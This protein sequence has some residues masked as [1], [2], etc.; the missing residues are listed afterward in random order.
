MAKESPPAERIDWRDTQTRNITLLAVLRSVM[1]KPANWKRG[2]AFA[3]RLGVS[4]NSRFR[5]GPLPLVEVKKVASQAVLY[6]DR[7][8]ASGELQRKF[9]R[10]QRQRG[11]LGGVA[12][13]K[14][15]A[16]VSNAALLDK[17]L[18]GLA[19]PRANRSGNSCTVSLWPELGEQADSRS[20]RKVL[21][22]EA[23]TLSSV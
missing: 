7:D 23:N 18:P 3:L 16:A 2:P 11:R 9:S 15:T 8:L 5:K 13:G 17:A 14:G 19:V 21:S 6:R 22:A 4:I 20:K 10:S 1:G 12:S